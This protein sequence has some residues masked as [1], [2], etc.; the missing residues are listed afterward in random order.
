MRAWRCWKIYKREE[1][2]F[3]H[4]DKENELPPVALYPIG[5]GELYRATLYAWIGPIAEARCPAEEQHNIAGCKYMAGLYGYKHFTYL[6]DDFMIC[7]NSKRT[8]GPWVG[9]IGEIELAGTVIEHEYGYRAQRAAVRSLFIPDRMAKLGGE[10]EA[11]YQVEVKTFPVYDFFCNPC[12]VSHLLL[13]SDHNVV[14]QHHL[15]QQFLT[16]CL[17]GR[18]ERWER[19]A[20]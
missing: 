6:T 19:S 8:R 18:I 14:Q 11:L 20:K 5:N 7:K 3:R 2:A 16:G 9:A 13:A 10:L 17:E 12:C 1:V 4:N 15:A